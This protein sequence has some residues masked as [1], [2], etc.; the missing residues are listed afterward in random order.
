[1]KNRDEK[2]NV[3]SMKEA[4]K[5]AGLSE[6]LRFQVRNKLLEFWFSKKVKADDKVG[7]EVCKQL[8][9]LTSEGLFETVRARMKSK[10]KGVE[11]KAELLL[12]ELGKCLL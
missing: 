9:R 3:W 12:R 7:T 5:T 8:S 6:E 4:V 10:D 2:A 11:A 1:M